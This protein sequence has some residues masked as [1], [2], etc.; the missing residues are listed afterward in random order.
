M[1]LPKQKR[2]AKSE[3]NIIYFIDNLNDF[4][5]FVLNYCLIL[6]FCILY[7]VVQNLKCVSFKN[8]LLFHFIFDSSN[9]VFIEIL[10]AFSFAFFVFVSSF[11][12]FSNFSFVLTQCLLTS[13]CNF[14]CMSSKYYIQYIGAQEFFSWVCFSL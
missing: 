8:F 1:L 14:Y 9:I 2:I 11:F 13:V 10:F 6:F 5:Y 4:Y 7:W 12:R 3:G